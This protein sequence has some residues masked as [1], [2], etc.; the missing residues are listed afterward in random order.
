MHMPL[1]EFPSLAQRCTMLNRFQIDVDS[2]SLRRLSVDLTLV[3][4]CVSRRHAYTE[5]IVF[6]RYSCPITLKNCLILFV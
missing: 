6:R 2:T 5:L 3:R 1:K 4:R